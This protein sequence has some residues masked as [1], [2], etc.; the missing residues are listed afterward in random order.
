M[1]PVAGVGGDVH[2][3]VFLGLF[4]GNGGE[5]AGDGVIRLA[6][7]AHQVQGDHGELAGG[8]GL[9]EQDLVLVGHIHQPAQLLLGLRKDL[10]EN[11]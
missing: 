6:G 10:H 9:E 11:L 1:V 4:G 3:A 5:V 7:A 8:P 2:G